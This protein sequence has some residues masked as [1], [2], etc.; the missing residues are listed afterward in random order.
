MQGREAGLTPGVGPLAPVGPSDR[1]V[2]GENTLLATGSRNSGLNS[3]RPP[4][5]VLQEPYISPHTTFL[6]TRRSTPMKRAVKFP[7][8]RN[9]RAAALEKIESSSRGS[10][11]GRMASEA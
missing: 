1:I 4:R 6:R 11:Y 3:R 10:Q 7:T 5:S 9:Y 2:L 8:R